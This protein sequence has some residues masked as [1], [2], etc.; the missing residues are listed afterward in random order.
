MRVVTAG[1]E[2]RRLLGEG[3][4]V[5][6]RDEAV[7]ATTIR[8]AIRDETE[9][10]TVD[11]P[12][13]SRRWEALVRP[14]DDT[15]PLDRLVAAARSRG[16]HPPEERALAAAQRELRRLSVEPVDTEA[17][18]R[19]L[20]DAGSEVER[21]RE[22]V[23][24]ARGRLQS[25]REMDADTAAAEAAL[26]DATKRLSAAETERVAAEQA[27]EAAQRRAREARETRERRLRL[28]DRV[29]NRRRDARRALV[30]AVQEAFATAVDA[31]PGTA[32]LSTAPLGVDGDEVTTAL[33]AARVA[34]LRAPVLDATDRF[35]SAAAAAAALEGPVIR[36]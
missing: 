18:R 5:D 13:P 34:D 26:E 23:A 32:S 8:A 36:V 22:E 24:A 14:D 3:R 16:H 29:A 19:R 7:S 27:H 33:A 35:D 6:L 15:D 2:G 30:S 20:A 28:Q 1:P 12:S 21:L 4:A 10:L 31:V 17:T 25:R 9:E 11:C